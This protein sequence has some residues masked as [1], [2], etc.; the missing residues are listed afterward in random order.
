MRS[1]CSFLLA[2][3]L[4]VFPASRAWGKPEPGWISLK[5]GRPRAKGI[6]GV[7]V[8]TNLSAGQG[9][10][11]VLTF[12]KQRTARILRFKKR[13]VASTARELARIGPEYVV[14]AVTPTT[15]DI[16]FHFEMLELCRN[17][18]GDPM[19]DFLFGYLCARDKDDMQALVDRVL[20]TT[21]KHA[22]PVPDVVAL[23]G[24]G[25]H[26]AKYDFI[27]HFGH[28][29]PWRVDKGLTGEQI[30]KLQLPR[31]PVVF[32]GACFNGVL[33]RSYH[34]CA[35][36]LIYLKPRLI[37]PE[38][39][40]TLNWVHA[41]V[42]GYLAALEGDRGEMAMAEWDYFRE[43]ACSLGEV[44]GYQ[45]RL[46]F[47]S[48]PTDFKGFPRYVPG[49]RK[50]MSFY[51]VML[52]GMVSRIL[53]SDP[54]YRPLSAPLDEPATVVATRYDPTSKT[55]EVKLEV[56]RWSQGQMLNYLPKPP[57]DR[58]D[59]RLYVR[60]AVPAA[61]VGRLGEPLIRVMHENKA[62]EI[63]RHH[64]RHEVWGGSRYL[65]L[66][67]EAPPGRIGKPGVTVTWTFP[68][69]R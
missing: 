51:N 2:L 45:Y 67:I 58:F 5:K 23:S 7:V 69:K 66:Q 19:P 42:S 64:L 37:A 14:V 48:L 63:T 44:I 55:L 40:M 16:N 26:L 21:R 52:R 47:T 59:R 28:G 32:S 31:N 11:A 20:K 3:A 36:Q 60:A 39:L 4:V 57:S 8:L 35:Y 54:A 56:K 15:V 33:S 34:P 62:V 25:E 53:L 1:T 50:L 68:V 22:Q 10:K 29:Q 65:N 6:G 61:A 30:G 49:K 38:K 12:A 27:L 17:L 9:R 41:G 18:D 43:R 46:A 13:D 24:T